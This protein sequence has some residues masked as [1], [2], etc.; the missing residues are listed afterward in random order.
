MISEAHS[1]LLFL[2]EKAE[3]R[4][5]DFRSRRSFVS[6]S[7]DEK[8]RATLFVGL[9]GICRISTG[10]GDSYFP[11]TPG[12]V[13]L[14]PVGGHVI[15]RR[16]KQEE[17]S[18]IEIW[19][20][21][22]IA[23]EYFQFLH[24]RYGRHYVL[25]E[26]RRVQQ[27]MR[28]FKVFAD[29]ADLIMRSRMLFQLFLLMH[30]KGIQR[31]AALRKG[32]RGDIKS[33]KEAARQ[34]SFSAQSMSQDIGCS[35][36]FLDGRFKR[37]FGLSFRRMLRQ[38]RLELLQESLL[39][40]QRGLEEVACEYGYSTAS[41]LSMALK[42][43]VG[44]TPGCLRTKGPKAVVHFPEPA[45]LVE[46][47]RVSV[48]PGARPSLV[49][50]DPFFH[51]VGGELNESLKTASNLSVSIYPNIHNWIYT[52]GGRAKLILDEAG[53]DLC[54]GRALVYPHPLNAKI[55]TEPGVKWHRVWLRSFDV[56][57]YQAF[58][59]LI[60]GHLFL[61]EIDPECLPVRLARRWGEIWSRRR[62]RPSCHG[63]EQAY[64]WLLSW[65]ELIAG[66]HYSEIEMPDLYRH[67]SPN[68][69]QKFDSIREY[70]DKFG[71]SRAHMSQKLAKMWKT[72]SPGHVLRAQR[73]VHAAQALQVGRE[74]VEKIAKAAHYAHAS[75]FVAA[76]KREYGMT[77]LQ[78]RYC[79]SE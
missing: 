55:I 57:S 45:L 14:M 56:F 12:M 1:R 69:Y 74:S 16:A 50:G 29:R 41:S 39:K 67:A 21:E 37:M 33:L 22:G 26:G 13:F 42:S 71:Y 30:K 48:L 27:I 2:F 70:S 15:F 66:G 43:L 36:A 63:S 32:V 61:L 8:R 31:T 35:C 73:L 28:Q 68:I 64:A 49:P 53:Y 18:F 54:A 46:P 40:E 60:A 52:I 34:Y 20:G 44:L 3:T 47:P 10:E 62:H 23:N 9:E 38:L 24:R 17:A 59:T 58:Q 75:S 11:L 79:Q 25:G 72:N 4:I 77:P 78:Y 76:F 7:G 19:P 51:Y 65:Y 5:M 6:V